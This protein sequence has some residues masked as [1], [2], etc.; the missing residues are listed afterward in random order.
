MKVKEAPDSAEMKAL[1]GYMAQAVDAPL[2][3]HAAEATRHHLLDT[4][5]A[6][7]SGSRL[8]PG[9]KAISFV[10][11][12]GGPAEAGVLGSPLVTSVFH[13][14]LA[15]GIAA[16]ADETDD[17]HFASKMH[18]GAPIVPAALA[19]AQRQNASGRRFLNAVALGYDVGTRVVKALDMPG[20]SNAYRSTHSF[21]GTFGAGAAAAAVMGFDALRMRYVLSYSAQL[22]AGCGSYMHD[23]G[24]IEKAFV[25]GG[26]PAQAGVLAALMVDD[27]FTAGPDVFTGERNFL[28]AFAARKHQEELSSGLGRDFAV[29][30][31]NIKKWCVGSPIQASLD[32]L[33]AIF[34]QGP[35]DPDAVAEIRITMAPGHIRTV[36]G[37][38]MPNVNIQHLVGL[39][40]V[41]GTITFASCHDESRLDDA[42]VARL[43]RIVRLVP[44]DTFTQLK[45]PRQAIVE[46][47]MR[48]GST[49]QSRTIAVRGTA[50]NPMNRAEVVAKAVDLMAP[51]L[52]AKRAEEV[53][54]AVL[55]VDAA[56]SI[57]HWQALFATP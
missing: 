9:K 53:C 57:A 20:F 7:V 26:R 23:S 36:D 31:T 19:M 49:R 38:P 40:L 33:Q 17:S 15:N 13:A 25:Y 18:P 8:W 54:A 22:A 28:D 42:R 37:R 32:A 30:E 48:D 52:G 47:Q 12:L 21:G 29:I 44:D 10:G 41:D 50:D 24:H 39:M 27:G 6:I 14:A 43:A 46:L 1:S 45:P 35:V 11:K 55:D 51:I 56:K 34:S 5:A 4:I 3:E 2:P 16:H